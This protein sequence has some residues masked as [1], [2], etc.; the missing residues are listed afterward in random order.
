MFSDDW[1]ELEID[2]QLSKWLAE[3]RS[4]LMTWTTIALDLANHPPD[5]VMTHWYVFWHWL[6]DLSS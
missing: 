1:I 6:V 2:R 5:R 4:C 3:W